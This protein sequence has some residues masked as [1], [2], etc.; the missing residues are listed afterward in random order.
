MARPAV[1]F[2]GPPPSTTSASSPACSRPVPWP[3][4]GSTRW[5]ST[6]PRPATSTS[7]RPP[8]GARTTS[9]AC[10]RRRQRLEL[11]A[12]PGGGFVA[13]GGGLFK[14]AAA[15]RHQRGR[16]RAAT[17]ARART[18]RLQAALDLAGVRYTGPSAAGAA[19]GMDKL[20]FGGVMAAAGLPSLP[21]AAVHR[22]RARP[23][24]P[25]AL[26]REAP[27]R[28][29][30]DR[31]RDHRRPRRRP[32]AGAA[33]RP[34][35]ATARSSSRTCPTPSRPERV[36]AGVPRA[37][38]VG[39]SRSRCARTRPGS[40][41]TYAEKYLG[42]GEGL[43]GAP[44]ELPA[45]LPDEVAERVPDLARRVAAA[46][47]GAGRAA[48]RLPVAGRRRVGERDQHDP[49]VDGVLLLG[50]PRGVASAAL[51]GDM[52]AEATQR[53]GPAHD[54]R[55]RRRHR[56]ALRRHHRRQARLTRPRARR[57]AHPRPKARSLCVWFRC[58]ATN[59]SGCAERARGDGRVRR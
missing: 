14:K 5:P 12:R 34:T 17:A 59:R 24:L 1:I 47:A 30:V 45:V 21:R 49:G 51:L 2:G 4:P 18:A 55:G 42:G 33:R 56:P 38:A 6:G 40:I 46:G 57:S 11:V 3:A 48:D 32:G 44:R 43:S 41:Y 9:P 19:L 26:H 35:S 53:P 28:R 22:R 36:G 52:L 31:H 20:A 39:A 37:A 27:L 23:R 16:E 54:D 13:E 10:R 25:R 29:L 7:C 8:R 50:A 15:A 58:G